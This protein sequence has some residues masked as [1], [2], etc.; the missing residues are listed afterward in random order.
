MLGGSRGEPLYCSCRGDA[1]ACI[2]GLDDASCCAVTTVAIWRTGG[3]GPGE[4][5][6]ERVPIDLLAICGDD[7][8][9]GVAL[10]VWLVSDALVGTGKGEASLERVQFSLIACICGTGVG[11]DFCKIS[12]ELRRRSVTGDGPGE[13]TVVAAE[14]RELR[15]EYWPPRGVMS[16]RPREPRQ[17]SGVRPGGVTVMSEA[18]L[19]ALRRRCSGVWPGGL[20]SHGTEG[21]KGLRRCSGGWPPG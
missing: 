16:E 18:W 12:N 8:G 20:T 15:S 4:L 5:A 13:V 1:K 7:K 21:R 19:T 6:G 10:G 14:R 11:E 3:D 9:V 2:G 17:F